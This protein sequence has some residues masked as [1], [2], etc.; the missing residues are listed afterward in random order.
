MYHRFRRLIL[1]III[2]ALVAG[3][4]F[5]GVGFG[6]WQ[7]YRHTSNA[8]FARLLGS[9]QQQNP[10]LD[11]ATLIHALTQA[12]E[13]TETIGAN[14]LRTYGYTEHD[15]SRPS[16]ESYAAALLVAGLTTILGIALTFAGYL[17]YHDRRYRHQVRN[18]VDY[19]QKLNDRIY[20]LQIEANTEDE[21]SLLANELYKITVTLKETAEFDRRTRR[22]LETALADISHQ[23]K[24]PLT[25][26]QIALDNLAADP[27]MPLTVRQD[28]LQ[29]SSRQVVAMTN[30][31]TTL[32]DLAKF[33]NGT[34]RMQRRVMPIGEVLNRAHKNLEI[35]ADLEDVHIKLGGDLSAQVKL[36]PH[37]QT[38]A[39]SNIIKNCLEH[40]P[41]GSTVEIS[42][43]DRVPYTRI[44]IRD[45]G[46]GIAPQD[47]H[48]IFE[49]FYKAANAS[50]TSVGIGLSFAQS[51]IEADHGQIQVKS[52]QHTEPSTPH[53]SPSGTTFTITYFH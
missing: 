6:T 50:A 3:A 13:T 19:V 15:F 44:I 11:T 45:H 31:I 29:A 39:L 14:L 12:D 30:L 36:D 10:E 34:I 38:E 47:L 43:E 51:V 20:D 28:F 35:L 40:S 46:A 1:P 25:S 7:Y 21:L 53:T 49:R 26:L 8:E 37:W 24:T 22:Q 23:L 42:V 17:Y 18:L 33:D 4:I 27:D 5:A 2:I 9:I 41:A 48:H 32:L 52:I 16:A